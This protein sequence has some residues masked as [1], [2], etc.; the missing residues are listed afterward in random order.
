MRSGYLKFQKDKTC[1]GFLKFSEASD[2]RCYPMCREAT[3]DDSEGLAR[4]IQNGAK[5]H[6]G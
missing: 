5:R 2:T 1:F 3:E 6:F 4:V